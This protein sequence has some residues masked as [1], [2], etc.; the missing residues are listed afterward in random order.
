MGD[1]IRGNLHTELIKYITDSQVH[2][3]NNTIQV[4]NEMMEQ[5]V[6]PYGI[7]CYNI[8]Q[9]S[10]LVDVFTESDIY[11]NYSYASFADWEIE[12]TPEANPKKLEFSINKPETDLK[13]IDFNINVSDDEINDMNNKEAVH[14]NSDLT[15]DD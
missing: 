8:H 10:I 12:K 5:E 3:T 11:N 7:Q 9:E 4:T 1:Q 2:T 14:P 13:K 15:D 6:K